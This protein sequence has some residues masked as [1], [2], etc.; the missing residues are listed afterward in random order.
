MFGGFLVTG[1]ENETANNIQVLPVSR[2]G[3]A[4]VGGLEGYEIAD[5]FQN[6]G[7]A[8]TA[9]EADNIY[10]LIDTYRYIKGAQ[11]NTLPIQPSTVPAGSTPALNPPVKP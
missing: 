8:F 7:S 4:W 11:M 5:F 3:R 2:W 6:L 1:Y 10:P 9:W